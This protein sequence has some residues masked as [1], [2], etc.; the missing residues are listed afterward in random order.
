MLSKK[1]YYILFVLVLFI[2]LIH[3]SNKTTSINESFNNPPVDFTK[4]I[5]DIKDKAERIKDLSV[6]HDKELKNAETNVKKIGSDLDKAKID[7]TNK[8]KRA[9]RLPSGSNVNDEK[10]ALSQIDRISKLL[11]E[12]SQDLINRRNISERT[13]KVS[14]TIQAIMDNLNKKIQP[15]TREKDIMRILSDKTPVDTSINNIFQLISTTDPTNATRTNATGTNATGTNATGTNATGTNATGTNAQ[16]VPTR[17]PASQNNTPVPPPNKCLALTFVQELRS[18]TERNTKLKQQIADVNQRLSEYQSRIN[19][20]VLTSDQNSALV[21]AQNQLN[22]TNNI[23]KK[24]NEANNKTKM[25]LE[26]QKVISDIIKDYEVV[27][28]NALVNANQNINNNNQKLEQQQAK[29]GVLV[30]ISDN[31]EFFSNIVPNVGIKGNG[32]VKT[33]WED[34][35]SL[36]L[37]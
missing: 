28:L 17:T 22:I 24:V 1:I 36:D 15:N 19:S 11:Q 6:K 16:S 10:K 27:S 13:K 32:K 35:W 31:K 5:R 37:Q 12:A 18:E 25:A 20:A 33:K 26:K 34:E 29:E 7:H 3:L 30:S 4:L 23:L 8:S 14:N 21:S 2:I 9:K